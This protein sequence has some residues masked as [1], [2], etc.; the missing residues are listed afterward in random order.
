[1]FEK[2]KAWCEY[3]LDNVEKHGYDVHGA[4]T[5]CYGIVMF[6][7]NSLVGYDSAKGQQIAKWWD[8]EMLPRFR[9]LYDRG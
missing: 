7:S 9:S 3:E 4:I 1:M 8:D 6:V 2:V 5:R